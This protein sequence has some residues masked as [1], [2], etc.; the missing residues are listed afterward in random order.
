MTIDDI[1]PIT[2]EATNTEIFSCAE[3]GDLT[4][5]EMNNEPWFVGKEVA[6]AL[7]YSNSSKAVSVHVDDEDKQFIMMD[8]ADSQN[9]NVPKG[10]TKTAFINE[11]GLYSLVLSSKLESA[12]RFKRW[13]TKDILPNIRKHGMYAT[14]EL[15]DNPDLL[16]QAATKLKEERERNKLLQEQNETMKPKALFADAVTASK[17]CVLIGELAKILKQNGIETGEK[18]LFSYLRKNGYLM[19]RK[20]NDKNFPTQ[21]SM[22]LGIM[23]VKETVITKSNGEVKINKTPMITG[24]GQLYFINKFKNM[25]YK[26]VL[27][28]KRNRRNNNKRGNN[29]RECVYCLP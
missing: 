13:V 6:E 22:D 10:K 21:K 24:K 4:V 1:T 19:K 3:F 7:G 11:S 20:G 18:R 2:G 25:G 17:D 26:N 28:K 29:S 5:L 12:K 8:I 23:Q 9:G 14:E 15:L 27:R 16:I